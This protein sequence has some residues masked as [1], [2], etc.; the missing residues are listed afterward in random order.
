MAPTLTQSPPAFAQDHVTEMLGALRQAGLR[1]TSQR[2]ALCRA[3]AD[4][5]TH[6]TA[7]ALFER[8]AP[9][10]PSLSR[11]TVYNTLE[12]LV[13]VGLAQELVMAG[14]GVMHYDANLSPHAHLVCTNCESIEDYSDEALEITVNR[15]VRRSG[16]D[17]RGLCVF[18]Y[19]LCPKCRKAR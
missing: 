1:I 3:L 19:G 5:L 14:N 6:P 12:M 2:V 18:Y 8:L 11:A 16:Y 9:E 10:F 7:Q 15:V 4:S 17:L 13:K